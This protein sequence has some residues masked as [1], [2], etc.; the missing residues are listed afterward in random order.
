MHPSFPPA[1]L[2]ALPLSRRKKGKSTGNENGK[3]ESKKGFPRFVN[4][5]IYCFP[6]P[7]TKSFIDCRTDLAKST[8]NFSRW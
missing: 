3:K 4:S 1:H 5:L 6:F 8:A 7:L 2:K